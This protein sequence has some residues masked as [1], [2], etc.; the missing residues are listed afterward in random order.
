MDLDELLGID[1]DD[2]EQ[3]L[4]DRLVRADD[5]LLDELVALRRKAMSQEKLGCLMGISQS[6][7]ARI[8]SGERDPHLSTL[9]RY[10]LAVG[11]DVRHIV[12]PFDAKLV[13]RQRVNEMLA[14]SSTSAFVGEDRHE[15]ATLA[16]TRPL[17]SWR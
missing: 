17:R 3:I 8:E 9:R 1:R 12:E 15:E 16:G 4:A 13:Q 7:V 5:S 10:A 6:A 2:P 11:A 14:S